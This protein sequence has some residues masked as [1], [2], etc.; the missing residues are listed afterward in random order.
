MKTIL[1]IS[2]TEAKAFFLTQK[3]YCSIDLPAYFDFQPLLNNLSSII[4]DKQSKDIRQKKPND[5]ESVNYK[6]YSN[7]DGRYDWRPLQLI[8]PALYI[9]LVN[10]ITE[11]NSW[12]LILERFRQFQENTN[13]ICCSLPL[14]DVKKID[15]STKKE[16]ILNW[17]NTIEQKSIEYALNYNC[18][19]N[20]DIV[21]CYGSIYT[22]SIPWAIHEKSYSKDHRSEDIIGNVIDQSIQAMSYSQTNGIPQGS[23]LCDFIAEIV[24]GYADLELTRSIESYNSNNPKNVIDDYKILR[25][26]DD[27]RIFTKNQE[28]AV[29]I[30]KLLSEVL[31]DLNFK[32][33]NQKTFISTNI[34][35]DSIKPDKLYWNEAKQGDKSLQKHLLLIHSLAEKY[36]NSGSVSKALD[37]FYDRLYSIKLFK[38]NNLAVL[39]SIM[40]DLL[41]KN[42][43]VYPIGCSILAKMLSLET[44]TKVKNDIILSIKKKFESIPNIG[45]LQVWLQRMTLKINPEEEYDEKLCKIVYGQEKEIW[46]NDWLKGNIKS[47]FKK[48]SIVDKSKIDKL[49]TIPE[50]SEIKVFDNYSNL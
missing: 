34:I 25:Y 50:P 26:R 17:W 1:E 19:L 16:T 12:A 15:K 32:L 31:Q 18:F 11:T 44:D 49:S 4:G 8:H 13:I 2:N 6:F 10:A 38:E 43:R 41:Y 24:L 48:T 37:K 40:V 14:V 47:V 30:A 20:T 45:H 21:N 9:C 29:V 33:N 39:I 42:P 46:N 3:A 27:Y 35:K 5:I 36:P 23:A 7:K 28:K 22:H